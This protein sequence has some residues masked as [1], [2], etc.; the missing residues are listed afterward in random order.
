MKKKLN[1]RANRIR[2]TLDADGDPTLIEQKQKF[3]SRG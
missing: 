2:L 3:K 1:G